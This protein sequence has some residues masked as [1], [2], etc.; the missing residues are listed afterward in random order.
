MATTM[1][2]NEW[3]KQK[4]AAD[5]AK[6]E[7]VAAANKGYADSLYQAGLQAQ[8]SKPTYGA[9][10]EALAA[11][12]LW[13]SGYQKYLSDSTADTYRLAANTARNVRNT[14]ITNANKVY[15]TAMQT[16]N[17]QGAA[18]QREAYSDFYNRIKY[19]GTLDANGNYVEAPETTDV[20]KAYDEGLLSKEYYDLLVSQMNNTLM[21]MY[22]TDIR[23][24]LEG[25][26]LK[27][28]SLLASKD[29]LGT[30]ETDPMITPETRDAITKIKTY[31]YTPYYN[32]NAYTSDMRIDENEPA[33]DEDGYA[34][35][36]M[37]YGNNGRAANSD[38]KG[39]R[40]VNPYT[41]EKHKRYHDVVENGE[42]VRVKKLDKTGK[43]AYELDLVT[44]VASGVPEGHFF[45]F[46]DQIYYNAGNGA[47]WRVDKDND[48]SNWDKIY[49]YIANTD[50]KAP[51]SEH[52]IPKDYGNIIGMEN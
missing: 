48:K 14:E 5:A 23:G 18:M 17:E 7:A 33:F 30:Y 10:A 45:Y 24:Y 4:A 20:Q 43:E 52:T 31:I 1:T 39:D 15:D 34:T 38:G 19:G 29:Y 21:E 28:P 12:G 46:R 36:R 35:I 26:S 50:D 27:L 41:G 37:V 16:V 25:D 9:G 49:N 3:M 2:Y 6:A 44:Q 47:Y 32:E 40:Y 51:K 8:A 13:G 22:G 11:R 42:K